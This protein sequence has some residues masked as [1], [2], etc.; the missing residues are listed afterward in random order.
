M[1]R[2]RKIIKTASIFLVIFI[3]LAISAFTIYL[4]WQTGNI[5][6]EAKITES[7]PAPFPV[8]V[9]PARKQITEN[10]ELD[11]FFKKHVSSEY[12]VRRSKSWTGRALAMLTQ[13]SWYQNLASLSGR[14]LVIQPGERKEE[15]AMNFG[16]ILGWDRI[17]RDEFISAVLRNPPE[18]PEGKFAPH[19]YF[20]SRRATP[21]EAAD[22][23]NA[24]FGKDFFSRYPTSTERTIPL[25]N[26]LTIASLIEREGK[27]FEDMRLI[28][29]IIWNRIFI[30]MKLQIDA[31]LQYAKGS[32]KSQPWW[33]RV[34]PADKQIASPFNTY[35]NFGLPPAPIANPSM[36]AVLAALN[37]KKTECIYYFHDKESIFHCS[38]TYKEHVALI[39]KFY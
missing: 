38:R 4:R 21:M 15:V 1:K 31:T 30:G 6:R 16:K 10:P 5:V 7:A 24:Q 20:A 3:G 25:K 14:I 34:F 12:S 29:G 36:D 13:Y 9:N 37:P 19:S 35:E 17:Q 28:S 18:L 32:N 39:K 8:G 11:S 22:L 26:A 33:P 27:D 2:S 23:V